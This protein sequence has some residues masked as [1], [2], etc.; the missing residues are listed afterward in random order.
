[1]A[2]DVALWVPNNVGCD[3]KSYDDQKK[4]ENTFYW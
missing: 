4:H 2:V 1:M 3:L